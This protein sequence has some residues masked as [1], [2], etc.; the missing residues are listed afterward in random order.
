MLEENSA[1]LQVRVQRLEES[2]TRNTEAVKKACG[3]TTA[4]THRPAFSFNLLNEIT[5]GQTEE[6]CTGLKDEK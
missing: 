4:K 3:E 2:V 5:Q 1:S 6:N